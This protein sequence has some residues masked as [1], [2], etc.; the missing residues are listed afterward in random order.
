MKLRTVK[1]LSKILYIQYTNPAC[2]PSLAHSSRIL[3]DMGWKVLFLGT[4]SFG[5]SDILNFK[6]HPNITVKKVSYCPAGWKQKL[7]YAFFCLTA[8]LTLLRWRPR[9]IYASEP[10]SCPIA[11]ILGHFPGIKIIYHEH[12]SPDSQQGAQGFGKYVLKARRDIA[13]GAALCI[14]P[15]EER[16]KKFIQETGRIGDTL[17]VW[18]CPR[19]EETAHARPDSVE[20]K[21]CVYYHGNIS[22]LFLPINMLEALK[23]LPDN[24]YFR[25]VGYETIG[26]NGYKDRLIVAARRLK[27][28]DRIEFIDAISRHDLLE[29][30][31]GSHIGLA[32]MARKHLSVNEKAMTGASNKPFDYMAC[33]LAL[34]VSDLPDWQKM[35]VEPGYGLACDPNDPEDIARALRWFLE[36]PEEAH[37]IGDRGRQKIL[38][39]WNYEKQ[40]EPV[41]DIINRP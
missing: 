24:V 37:K 12:D 34:L 31:A 19:K 41:L 18:N 11:L 38:S 5:G 23:T 14:L 4:G 27:I 39:E 20:T 17:S 16:V 15:N 30:C 32:L 7:H 13:A 35:Y 21:F 40:F 10:L 22:D 29:Y 8:F 36:H 25:I 2:Y 1:P 26:S 9:W 28:L 33:G 3:A 6:D